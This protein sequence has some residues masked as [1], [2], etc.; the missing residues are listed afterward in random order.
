[1][2]YLLE[3]FAQTTGYNNFSAIQRFAGQTPSRGA[4]NTHLLRVKEDYLH[5]HY[6]GK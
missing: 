2:G 5:H 1:M 3:A 6:F 4:R